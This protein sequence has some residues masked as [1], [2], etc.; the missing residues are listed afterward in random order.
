MTHTH[1]HTHIYIHVEGHVTE[2][3][4]PHTQSVSGLR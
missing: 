2:L 3:E 4:P 1:T